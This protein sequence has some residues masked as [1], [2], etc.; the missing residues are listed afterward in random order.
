M[1]LTLS[2]TS[3]WKSVITDTFIPA[4]IQHVSRYVGTGWRHV[5]TVSWYLLATV[6]HTYTYALCRL[7]VLVFNLCRLV[8]SYKKSCVQKKS[9]LAA[10]GKFGMWRLTS[11]LDQHLYFEVVFVQMRF[12]PDGSIGTE[13][14]NITLIPIS[15]LA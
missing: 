1:P 6:Y 2:P 13:L 4:I 7:K 12:K 5:V 14:Y 11:W 9:Q 10:V 15:P 8:E 3:P